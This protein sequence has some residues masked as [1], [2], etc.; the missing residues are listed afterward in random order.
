[1][2][3]LFLDVVS[4]LNSGKIIVECVKKFP[5]VDY[6]TDEKISVNDE[7]YDNIFHYL[8]KKLTLL[9]IEEDSDDKN[10]IDF[11]NYI[12]EEKLLDIKN[13]PLIIESIIMNENNNIFKF[14]MKSSYNEDIVASIISNK[15]DKYINKNC[16]IS[17]KEN[18]SYDHL[19]K[20]KDGETLI[21]Y[22]EKP[23]LIDYMVNENLYNFK[24][25]NKY[26]K[27]IVDV[28]MERL[29]DLKNESNKRK[30]INF[31]N[32]QIKELIEEYNVYPVFYEN[33]IDSVFNPGMLPSTFN[34]LIS[35]LDDNKFIDL[36]LNYKDKKDLN[37]LNY[38]SLI[39][40]EKNNSVNKN[41][42]NCSK[43]EMLNNKNPMIYMS[44]L[45]KEELI[46]FIDEFALISRAED[47]LENIINELY[48]KNN[49]TINEWMAFSA[50]FIQNDEYKNNYKNIP[51]STKRKLFSFT[52]NTIENKEKLKEGLFM[53]RNDILNNRRLKEDKEILKKIVDYFEDDLTFKLIEL[54]KLG[55]KITDNFI[56][57]LSSKK[58]SEFFKS[59]DEICNSCPDIYDMLFNNKTGRFYRNKKTKIIMEKFE[60]SKNLD[61]NLSTNLKLKR[62]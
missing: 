15:L 13:S 25:V 27:N 24:D 20:N 44:Y 34:Y 43:I 23:S 3:K 48:K 62:L 33:I 52:I 50:S 39:L 60:I 61:D 54:D 51:E 46:S 42:N 18:T 57:Y 49:I 10:L 8:F 2:N 16:F 28:F 6:N 55:I 40:N 22:S 29:K 45:K 38:I 14:M 37:Y 1:M 17:M 58:S 32:K 36:K 47:F 35:D 7:M 11:I 31:L 5:G 30:E 59:K 9:N 12:L 21:F 4:N 26:N 19:I 41:N 53:I 56:N